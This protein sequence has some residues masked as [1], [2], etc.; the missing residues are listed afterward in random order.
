MSV[1]RIHLLD[2]SLV[3]EQDGNA[4]D[5]KSLRTQFDSGKHLHYTERSEMS[6]IVIIPDDVVG[7][8]V[9]EFLSY[10]DAVLFAD[11][12]QHYGARLLYDL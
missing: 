12:L 1:V 9:Q 2:P 10:Y 5:C 8:I 4:R 7:D 3:L 11:S 6:W